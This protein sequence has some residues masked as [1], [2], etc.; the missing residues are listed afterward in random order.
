MSSGFTKSTRIFGAAFVILFLCIT[1]LVIIALP[2]KG[3]TKEMDEVILIGKVSQ[4]NER[5]EEVA[6][7]YV[8]MKLIQMRGSNKYEVKANKDGEFQI[9]GIKP[10]L[11]YILVAINSYSYKDTVYEERWV[12]DYSNANPTPTRIP[13]EVTRYI[14]KS[15]HLRMNLDKPGKYK[16]ELNQENATKKFDPKWEPYYD[17]ITHQPYTEVT[18][19]VPVPVPVKTKQEE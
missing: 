18:D 8:P 1:F 12:S 3:Y 16:V 13:V 11:N 5:K 6:C 15:W 9:N 10:S 14:N 19:V 4:L 7:S 2:Q 17:P